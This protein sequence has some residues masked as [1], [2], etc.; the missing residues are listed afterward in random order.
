MQSTILFLQI[1]HGS[2]HL[3]GLM[4]MMRFHALLE[5]SAH[6]I[7][8]K[9][10]PNF[11]IALIKFHLIFSLMFWL[12]IGATTDRIREHTNPYQS[13]VLPIHISMNFKDRAIITAYSWRLPL[14]SW[15]RTWVECITLF[16]IGINGR[17]LII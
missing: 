1:W 10:K 5:T 17:L 3:D 11:A 7:H 9:R 8:Y 16:N 4:Y 15:L 12:E 13:P 6:F 2:V 14:F